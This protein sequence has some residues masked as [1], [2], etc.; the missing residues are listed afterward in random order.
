MSTWIHITNLPLY[1]DDY[2][3]QDIFSDIGQITATNVTKNNMIMKSTG[4]VQFA[5]TKHAKLAASKKDQTVI[6]NSAVRVY[7]LWTEKEDL[8]TIKVKNIEPQSTENDLEKYF[9][10]YGGIVDI[11]IIDNNSS[12]ND[13]QKVKEIEDKSKEPSSSKEQEPY[14]LISFCRVDY[15]LQAVQEMNG[16]IIGMGGALSVELVNPDARVNYISLYHY[17]FAQ[18]KYMRILNIFIFEYDKN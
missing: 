2:G 5:N 6:A 15:A 12:N 9:D 11:R 3:L 13:D 10:P 7:L 16:T 4:F 18:C 1:Y 17:I 8:S 14:A